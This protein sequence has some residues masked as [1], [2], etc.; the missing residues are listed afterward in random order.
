MHNNEL[1]HYGILGQKWGVRRFQNPD[2][3]R[4]T[5]GKARYSNSNSRKVDKL[6]DQTIKGGKDKPNVSPAEKTVNESRKIIDS[7]SQGLDAIDRLRRRSKGTDNVVKEMSDEELRK[8]INRMNLEKQYNDLTNKDVSLGMETAK[9]ILS[10]VG[11]TVAI[12]GGVV[13]IYSTLKKL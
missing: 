12:V 9:D 11:S 2:G 10:V 4:T 3:S 7:A 5:A 6:F 8:A 1:M 13:T